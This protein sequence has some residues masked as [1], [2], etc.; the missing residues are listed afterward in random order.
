MFG[1]RPDATLVRD[2]SDLRRIMPYISPRRN[3]SLYSATKE[4]AVDALLEHLE[5]KNARRPPERPVTLFHCFLRSTAQALDLRPEANRF[6][7]GGHFWQ[8]HG[9]WLTFSAKRAMQDG[10]PLFTVKRRFEPRRESLD[11]MADAIYERLGAGRRGQKS[12]SDKETALL[13]R[14]PGFVVGAAIGLAQWADRLGLLPAAMIEAD[15][16]FTS[17]FV[18]NVGS[19][20][21]PAGQHHLWEY[22]TCSIF[23]VIGRIEIDPDGRRRIRVG[24]CYDERIADGLYAHYVLD[25]VRE[26]LEQPELLELTTDELVERGWERR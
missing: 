1:H 4:V 11:E 23:A 5:K 8:R 14:F 13:L 18:A 24:W 20:D 26:R 16:L 7:K 9:E 15:P 21:E 6:V 12:T 22:G 3:D 19:I 10:A 17:A 25:G 2:L